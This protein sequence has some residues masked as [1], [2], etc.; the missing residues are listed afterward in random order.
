M[1][2]TKV[3]NNKKISNIMKNKY[4]V[5]IVLI[6]NGVFSWIPMAMYV[7]IPRYLKPFL[8]YRDICT[9]N[10]LDLIFSSR[11][12]RRKAVYVYPCVTL[13]NQVLVI[14][15]FTMFCYVSRKS[16]QIYST[17]LREIARIY[18]R[19]YKNK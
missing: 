2:T 1:V 5:Y 14:R 16:F 10:L 15:S 19:G 17:Y 9:Y 18:L 6:S 11:S 4:C 12:E 3:L 7:T 13:I 8:A